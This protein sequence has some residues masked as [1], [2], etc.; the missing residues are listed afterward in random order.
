VLDSAAGERLLPFGVRRN[1]VT[2]GAQGYPK[3]TMRTQADH[4]FQR[5]LPE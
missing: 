2:Q 5:K 3:L 4:T 1:G